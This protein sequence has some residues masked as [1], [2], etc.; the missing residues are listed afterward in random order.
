M[1]IEI[2]PNETYFTRNCFVEMIYL[3]NM[4]FKKDYKCRDFDKCKGL[5]SYQQLLAFACNI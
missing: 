1:K 5:I 3:P 4:M 2:L